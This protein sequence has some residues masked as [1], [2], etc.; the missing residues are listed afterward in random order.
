[1]MAGAA[2]LLGLLVATPA[3]AAPALAEDSTRLRVEVVAPAS[4]PLDGL[5]LDARW[6]G[7][8]RSLELRDDGAAPDKTAGDGTWSGELTGDWVR[9]LPVELYAEVAGSSQLA[10]QGIE[11][12]G[13]GAHAMAFALEH[14]R[15]AQARRLSR[16]G[17]ADQVAA[18]EA[19]RTGVGLAWVLALVLGVGIALRRS[20][21]G[22]G[23]A[24]A[25]SAW[26]W[27]TGSVPALW[28]LLALVWTWPAALAGGELAVGR[29]FDL[30]GT[31]WSISAAGR[32]VPDLLDPLTAWPLGGD[33]RR[34]DSYTL[35][36][37]AWL[38][39]GDPAR[40]HGWLQIVGV[41]SSGWAAQHFARGIGA[42]APWDLLGG[43]LF[44]LS[45]LAANGLLEGHV[46]LLL[47]PWLPLFG[48]AW[49][50]ATGPAGTPRQAAAA[51]VFFVLTLLTSAYLGVAAAV[52]ALAFFGAG[53]WREGNRIWR[54][55]WP[56]AVIVGIVAVPYALPFL[57]ASGSASGRDDPLAI[58]LASAHLV[59]LSAPTPEI[60][61]AAH[62]LSLA[63]SGV[64]VALLAASG[65][66]LQ[67]RQRWGVLALGAVLCLVLAMGPTLAPGPH[68][69][70]LPL[71]GGLLSGLPGGDFLRFPARL[72]WGALLCG[73]GLAALAGTALEQ[74]LGPKSRVLVLL[75]L[76]EAVVLVGMPARQGHLST[77][78]S[79]A[80]AVVDGPI[81]DLFPEGLDSGG[82]LES[83]TTGLAC[84]AQLQHRRP[85][86]DDCV[87]TPVD[88]G[89]RYQLGRWLTARLLSGEGEQAGQALAT[90]GFAGVAVHADLF[91]RGDLR[92]MWP[93][94]AGWDPRPVEG[95]D[96]GE[97]LI[98]FRVPTDTG[99]LSKEAAWALRED[100]VASAIGSGPGKGA[101][102]LRVEVVI[103]AARQ[104]RSYHVLVKQPDAPAR[105]LVIQNTG[106]APDDLPG[107]RVWVGWL[108]QPLTGPVELELVVEEDD[109]DHVAWSGPVQ[110]QGGNERV[111]FRQLTEYPPRYRPLTSAPH[112]RSQPANRQ[113]D[114]IAAIGWGLVLVAGFGLA[115]L[116]GLARPR[117]RRL[118]VSLG[119]PLLLCPLAAPSGAW[120]QATRPPSAV[121][122]KPPAV[123][124][125]ATGPEASE[126]PVAEGGGEGFV[127]VVRDPL[128]GLGR[129][130]RAVVAT[131]SLGEAELLLADDGQPPDA[132]AGDDILTGSVAGIVGPAEV[133]IRLLDAEGAE[134][135]SD[136]VPLGPAVERPVVRVVLLGS[137]AQVALATQGDGLPPQTGPGAGRAP[138]GGPDAVQAVPPPAPGG[139]FAGDA[140][141]VQAVIGLLGLAVG[142]WLGLRRGRPLQPA[143][144][145]LWPVDAHASS[146]EV[147]LLPA[148]LRRPLLRD[149][150]HAADAS[151]D[152]DRAPTLVL[153]AGPLP[154]DP[155]LR[156]AVGL[157]D[158]RPDLEQVLAAA[159]ALGV[160]GRVTMLV[161]GPGALATPAADEPPTLLVEALAGNPPPGVELLLLLVE[162]ELPD[163]DSDLP[164][165]TLPPPRR[166]R[167]EGDQLVDDAGPVAERRAGR[168]VRSPRPVQR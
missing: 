2:A 98:V 155:A 42:R 165:T 161:E 58:Q 136:K 48:L 31:L 167:V 36:P 88:N 79:S 110:L 96:G 86:S 103:P 121:E 10:Y 128:R 23:G 59:A 44:A 114:A 109:V 27:P 11:R 63:L 12:V 66:L 1:M 61:R 115:I 108:D 37:L 138:G 19:T 164:P 25:A 139:A 40:L 72:G 133:T 18:T 91:S 14:S 5:R 33:Y 153:P 43:V 74:R 158:A 34:F 100:L 118:A 39:G 78:T 92:R 84:L 87:A 77:V 102:S 70:W 148:D 24:P 13:G 47:N 105:T 56:A 93:G 26:R 53:W 106:S 76:V 151:A 52:L 45:G 29:H 64:M 67:R 30:P 95:R 81:L 16:A 154:A 4:E 99:G 137:R 73:A 20:K 8:E 71:P 123:P 89:P 147:W 112:A 85:I 49:W 17:T 168:W 156:G 157:L 152:Q 94:L 60:D 119:L 122:P 22:G 160:L 15:P 9:L 83:W 7:E 131:P 57:G 75:A 145:P 163:P 140:L 62:S 135:W 127:L 116:R 65:A 51:G 28:L 101:S 117:V 141:V 46:Y 21:A 6:L 104:E 126:L 80:Y 130:G 107:D 90:L 125:A 146:V 50:R 3:Q 129:P 143:L 55:A 132:V 38:Y 97:R 54:V 69:R 32:L 142:A 166:L 111:V 134:A 162:A 144:R 35:L 124:E 120:A 149:L 41:A 82:E 150:A 113:S 159:A 68:G